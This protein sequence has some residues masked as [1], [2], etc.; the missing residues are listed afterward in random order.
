MKKIILLVF[1]MSSLN[2]FSQSYFILENGI[3]IT[4]D[5]DGFVYDFGNYT[6]INRIT[7]KGAQYLV[8]DTNVLVT[9]DEK[10]LLYRQYEMLPKQ[11]LGKGM[12]YFIGD[13]SNLFVVDNLGVVKLIEQDERVKNMVKCGG[14]YFSTSTD[15]ILT[16]ST[17]GDLTEITEEG[18][19][20]S[21]IFFYG[22]TYFM[23]NRGV[24]YTISDDGKI[25][26][27][28]ERIGVIAKKGGNYFI[29][30]TGALYTIS[31]N[32]D[33]KMPSVPLTLRIPA[34]TR[35]GAN[36]F[37]D[38]DGKLFTVDRSGNV[39]E[40]T[41]EYDLRSAKVISL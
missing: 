40:R 39:F 19:K 21:D 32:G 12:N 4:V 29:D 37:M 3:T 9:F 6:P 17:R 8:E 2:V 34:I 20:G 35:L 30:A 25:Q 41:L 14:R 28:A 18:L 10:G 5:A 13:N 27:R 33:L 1:L 11:V 36:Y 15:Q 22:G 23:T 38:G 24:L 7:I 26:K 31:E 16:I